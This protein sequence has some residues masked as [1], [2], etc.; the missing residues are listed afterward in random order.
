MQRRNFIRLTGAT[1][2]G[3][4]FADQGFARESPK[5]ALQIPVKVFIRLEDGVHELISPDKL[6]W[7]YKDVEVKLAHQHGVLSV[8]LRAP[9]SAVFN[10]QMQWSYPVSNDA[11]ILGDHW[12]RTY[13]DV[14]FQPVNFERKLPWY[15]IEHDGKH[16]TC[17][18]V[19]TG[20]S[21][22]CYWQAGG[23]KMQLTLDVRS[24]GVGVRLGDRRL[25]AAE[26]VATKN[27]GAEN[28]FATARRFCGMMCETPRLPKK[29][30]YGG[31]DW[32]FAYGK[33]SDALILE[34]TTLLT[35]LAPDTINRPFSLVDA[36][37][38]AYSPA[39]PDDCCW[40]DDFSRPNDHF[41]DMA[42]LA[43]NIQQ[44]GMQPGIW[45]RP[46][47]A[48]HDDPA[49]LL[50]PKIPGRDNPKN[51]ILDPTIPENMERVKRNISLYNQWGYK[52]V[53]HDFSTYDILGKWGF[54]MAADVTTPGWRFSDDSK[55]TAEIIL[56]LYRS[57][58][59]AAGEMYLIGCNTIGHLSAGVFELN[60]VGDDTSGNEWE[61][62]RKM[63]VNTLGFR[64]VQHN[65]FFSADGDCVG[66]T[67]KVAWEKNKQW[68]QLVAE[69]ST[70]LFI[71]AQ[72]DAVG[73]EQ[74]DFIK[75]CFTIAAK[76]LPVAE[77]I[78]WLTNERP[79]K[80][81][82]N[83]QLKTFDWS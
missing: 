10:V 76:P 74:K 9:H 5:T 63:G 31:N 75:Q 27:S 3:L 53:K 18:G 60:R 26:I 70:P 72:P 14:N 25:R 66:L 47:C 45:T 40:G 28:A 17:F 33:N 8:A 81:K 67:H 58:R 50:L 13:G 29:P 23:G 22:I 57:I 1:L 24:G 11:T 73:K 4:L 54:E 68:M 65:K 7:T 82:L 39:L 2:S 55:T 16:T 77:P 19:K 79:V 52:M 20:G 36:G 32:Y 48:R 41:K 6:T 43:E 78:D 44:L 30:V 62:T 12:E 69:S 56:Q 80:W 83:N 15:F 34:H 49:S 61:R 42:K 21:A 59:D 64:M 71:S 35:E 51:P 46:L 37:W 38:A